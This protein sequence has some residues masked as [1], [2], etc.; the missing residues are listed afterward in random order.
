M[1]G[2]GTDESDVQVDDRWMIQGCGCKTSWP[3]APVMCDAFGNAARN[4]APAR[5]QRHLHPRAAHSCGP[6][7][8][9]LAA[10]G[11]EPA[12][13][14]SQLLRLQERLHAC[15]QGHGLLAGT[16]P[17]RVRLRRRVLL[18]GVN[19]LST[20]MAFV[21]FA[22]LSMKLAY[23]EVCEGKGEPCRWWAQC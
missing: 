1:K 13:L 14:L 10:L 2:C 17:R 19:G 8:H 12:V 15:T 21:E 22:A 9:V 3:K 18:C 16:Q 23:Q 6:H 4:W 7:L 20:K 11:A 5:L